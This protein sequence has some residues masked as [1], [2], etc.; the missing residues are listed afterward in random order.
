MN[1]AEKLM[2][3]FRAAQEAH[4][5][6]VVAGADATDKDEAVDELVAEFD[7]LSGKLTFKRNGERTDFFTVKELGPVKTLVTALT[8]SAS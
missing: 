3:D 1:T 5:R 6:V 7:A 8:K 2:A 4:R